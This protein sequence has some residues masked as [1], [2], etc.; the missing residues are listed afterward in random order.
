M[1]PAVRE[2]FDVYHISVNDPN[3]SYN[4]N[5]RINNL[6][7]AWVKLLGKDYYFIATLN[8]LGKIISDII[9]NRETTTFT[10]PINEVSW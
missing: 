9:I 8:D 6:D 5:N 2:K 1:L 3:N 10:T 7:E 4:F